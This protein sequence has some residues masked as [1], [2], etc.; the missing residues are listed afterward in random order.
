METKWYSDMWALIAA[1]FK[2][3]IP[4]IVE[5]GSCQKGFY[6]T[7]ILAIVSYVFSN[8][9]PTLV[10]L[11]FSDKLEITLTGLAAL[12]GVGILGLLVGLFFTFVGIAI[13]SAIFSWVANKFD[14]HTTYASILKIMWYEQAYNHIM[15]LVYLIGFLLVSAPFMVLLG[16]NPNS[17]IISIIWMIVVTLGSI[18]FGFFAFWVCLTLL[19]HQINKSR[20]A[21]FGISLLTSLIP[22]LVVAALVGI[23]VLANSR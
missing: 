20:L 10:N 3:G 13:Y 19:S 7:V 16:F 18:G 21:T 14:A 8:I 12:S 6:A 23:V 2:R 5:Q 22:V 11:I 4:Q 15:G 17:T 9:L 1:P